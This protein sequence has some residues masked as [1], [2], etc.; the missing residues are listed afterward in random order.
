[1]AKETKTKAAKKPAAIDTTKNQRADDVFLTNLTEAPIHIFAKNDDGG[2]SNV[3]IAPTDVVRVGR[4]TLEIGGVV[5]FLDEKRLKQVD[6]ADYD[7][8]KTEHDGALTSDDE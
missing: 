8:L 1:M 3:I 7:K 2:I 4:G 5:Q 6:K